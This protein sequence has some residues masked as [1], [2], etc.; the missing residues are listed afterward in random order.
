MGILYGRAGR[1]NTENAGFRPG[2]WEDDRF[3]GV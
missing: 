1:F 2:Q 3:D